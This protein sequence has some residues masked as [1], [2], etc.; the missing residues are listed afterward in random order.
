MYATL[1]KLAVS[2]HLIDLRSDTVSRPSKGMREA[3]ASADVGDDV[4]GDDPTVTALEEQVADLL[5]KE[6]ALFVASGTQSNLIALLSHCGRGEEYIG[7]VGYHIAKYE[8]GGAA[9]LGGISPRHLTP[10]ESGALV[11]EEIEAAVQPDDP[12]FAISRLLCLE[13]TFNGRV[14]DQAKIE[15]ACAVARDNGLSIHIDGARLLNAAVAIGRS[16]QELVAPVDTVSLC[17]SKGLGAPVGSVL[18]GPKDFIA[19]ARRNRK[20]VGGGLRQSGVLAACGLY[21][22]HNNVERLAD[23]HANARA[24]AQKLTEIDGVEI[25]MNSVQT[26]MIWLRL[27]KRGEGSFSTY[28]LE[29]GIIIG[30]P[31]PG[32][33]LVCH[34]DFSADD[35]DKVVDGF[36][37]WLR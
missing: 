2:N 32:M 14:Q 20:M 19:K 33:R 18:A 24:M 29:R 35:I 27:S 10:D 31:D 13:N 17:L 30:E 23:D 28:M 15:A 5:G 37:G 26:N 22:L 25:D 16:A 12:H 8:A 3:M 36:A 34:L 6:E 7:G 21:A 4:Y 9:V 11:P 1:P